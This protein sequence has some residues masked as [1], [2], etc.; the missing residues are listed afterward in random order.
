MVP[1]APDSRSGA[2][3]V[4]TLAKGNRHTYLEQHAVRSEL[5]G[6]GRVVEE[7]TAVNSSNHLDMIKAERANLWPIAGDVSGAQAGR[8][9]G[10]ATRT[11]ATWR[12][13]RHCCIELKG[14]GGAE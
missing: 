3:T 5:P 14:V 6:K 9:R 12:V 11:G 7:M 4:G 10:A 1:R 8:H 13:Q 2:L